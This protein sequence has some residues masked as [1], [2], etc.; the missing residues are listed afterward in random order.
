M[1]VL[2]RSIELGTC[3]SCLSEEVELCK[4][5]GLDDACCESDESQR[6]FD[7]EDLGKEEKNVLAFQVQG[8]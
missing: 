1:G 4:H 3:P 8:S 5:C 6:Q 2:L 7:S